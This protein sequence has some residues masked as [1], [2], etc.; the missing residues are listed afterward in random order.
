MTANNRQV[1]GNHYKSGG[2]EHWDRVRRLDLN[3][4]QACATKYIERCYLKNNPLEDLQKAQHFI[5]K[6]IEIEEND[7]S[8]AGKGYVNQDP[9]ILYSQ[10][11]E[12]YS[13]VH[14]DIS[15]KYEDEI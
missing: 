8:G 6:L 4:F 13:D 9:D 12:K 2:E 3:Y 7:D 15:L 11:L 14:K 10:G 5:Q 1:G